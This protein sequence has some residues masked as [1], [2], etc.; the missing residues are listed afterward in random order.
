MQLIDDISQFRTA[1]RRLGSSATLGL[2]PTM[3]ALHEGHASLVKK[4]VA[5]N[6]ITAV[7]IFVNPTQFGAGE[8]FSVY[9]RTLEKDCELL[10]SLGVDIVFAPLTTSIYHEGPNQVLFQIRELNEMLC[11]HSRPGH[12]EGVLQVVSILF[13]IIQ[14]DHA[15]F[16]EKDYQQCLLIRQ[17]VEELHFPVTVVPCPIIREPD[18]LAMSSRNIYLNTKEREQAL[19]L[20]KT[21]RYL[22]QQIMSFQTV[23]A[24]KEYVLAEMGHYPL[25]KLDYF[26]VLNDTDLTIINSPLPHYH[27]RAF[28]AAYLGKT[29][30]IDNMALYEQI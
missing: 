22:A 13:N 3:G 17:M 30:L 15:Y 11:G 27:P 21:L 12:F 6:D 10:E 5:Q 20:S 1:R 9:P 16:G 23:E 25:I 19:F 2:V 24:I 26:E 8:D 29:R 4:S 7:S 18:G 28:I 14:P